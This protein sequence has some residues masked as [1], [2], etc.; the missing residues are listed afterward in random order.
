MQ[1][2]GLAAKT[3][4]KI[5]TVLVTDFSFTLFLILPSL[6]TTVNAGARIITFLNLYSR[7]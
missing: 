2:A 5:V 6:P 7:K 4:Y 3:V 1:L